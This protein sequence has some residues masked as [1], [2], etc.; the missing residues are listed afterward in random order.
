[1][2]IF[3]HKPSKLK[4]RT[5]VRTLDELHRDNMA[6]F[7][8]RINK[9]PDKKQRLTELKDELNSLNK[10]HGADAA[11]RKAAIKS[12]IRMLESDI[13][14]CDNNNEKLEYFSKTGNILFNYYSATSGS[15]YNIG[16]NEEDKNKEIDLDEIMENKAVSTTSGLIVSDKLK[17]LNKLSQQDRKIK[18]PVKKRKVTYESSKAQNKSILNFLPTDENNVVETQIVVNRA[19]LQDKFLMVTDPS[20]A[21]DKIKLSGIKYCQKCNAEMILVQSEGSYICPNTTCGE[22][23]YVIIESEIPSH[24]DALNEKPK[25]PYKK[26]NH[27]KEKLSQFQA[28]ETVDIPEYI[29]D[30]IKRE[31]RK[32]RIEYTRCTPRR[33]KKII[34][35]RRFV[36]YYEHV[37]QI[38]CKIS[39]SPPMTLSRET[40]ELVI[41]M[42]MDMQESFRRHCPNHRSNFLNYSYVLN[43]I[44][45]ILQMWRHSDCFDLLKSKDKLKEQDAIWYNIC[46]DMGWKYY[47]SF[48][49]VIHT[50]TNQTSVSTCKTLRIIEFMSKKNRSQ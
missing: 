12:S 22:V 35:K 34:K 28:K 16:A 13:S 10:Q 8:D 20:Y 3:K 41:S 25:Y 24:K 44:F 4:Y 1:M 2:P 48:G 32:E 23:E 50:D 29:Y 7:N 47:S 5:P 45:K 14:R 21:C 17:M 36:N 49:D 15:F 19:S 42:F 38:Y 9:L 43:K 33:I 6:Q 18:K 11:K 26:V 46:Q 27:L 31:L 37:Q 39:D 40:E 30:V